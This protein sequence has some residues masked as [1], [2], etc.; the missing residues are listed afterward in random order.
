MFHIY[1]NTNE[2]LVK[3]FESIGIFGVKQ[4]DPPCIVDEDL[5]EVCPMSEPN[6]EIQFRTMEG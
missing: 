5:I 3:L 4:I 2:D 6:N 1:I